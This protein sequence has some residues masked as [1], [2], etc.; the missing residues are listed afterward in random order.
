MRP[1]ISIWVASWASRSS[2]PP[3]SRDPNAPHRR[4]VRRR[5]SGH[6]R[7]DLAGHGGH[8]VGAEQVEGVELLGAVGQLD[9]GGETHG[10]QAAVVLA[11]QL[12]GPDDLAAL[13]MGV[14]GRRRDEAH[15]HL[16]RPHVLGEQQVPVVAGSQGRLVEADAEAEGDEG[17]VELPGPGAVGGRVGQE[18]VPGGIAAALCHWGTT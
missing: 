14:G 12:D 16:R 6:G 18:D 13:E 7:R 15:D 5:R 2:R 10:D 9:I 11:D 17:V 8:V 4:A 3:K 1:A